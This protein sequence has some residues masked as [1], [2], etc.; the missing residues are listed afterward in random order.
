M[1]GVMH[2]TLA[3]PLCLQW[4]TNLRYCRELVEDL[5]IPPK[6]PPRAFY[7]TVCINIMAFVNK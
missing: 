4:L 3:Q 1:L 2:G 6:F 5:G 7:F